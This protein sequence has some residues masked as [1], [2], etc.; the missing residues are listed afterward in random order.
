MMAMALT[1]SCDCARA[2]FSA[3]C[4][5]EIGLSLGIFA[6]APV[7]RVAGYLA[8]ALLPAARGFFFLG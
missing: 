3:P 6:A 4:S 5:E 2:A 1:L 8:F 7:V